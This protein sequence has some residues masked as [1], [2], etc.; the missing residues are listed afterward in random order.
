MVA[1]QVIFHKKLFYFFCLS[2]DFMVLCS[3]I[4]V[5]TLGRALP[6]SEKLV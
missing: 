1:N 2:I 6:T 3:L 4:V 5:P